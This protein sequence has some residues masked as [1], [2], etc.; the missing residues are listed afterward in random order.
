MNHHFRCTA[1]GKCCVGWVPLGVEEIAAQAARFPIAMV[2]TPIAAPPT[3]AAARAGRLAIRALPTAYVPPSFPCPQLAA[4]GL[5]AI[6]ATKPQRCRTMPFWPHRPEADQAAMLAPRDGWACDVSA[7][8]PVVYQ[9]GR[10]LDRA[11]FDRERAMMAAQAPV[12][13][14]YV[15]AVMKAAPGLSDIL[16]KVAATPG[17][18]VVLSITTLLPHLSGF[19]AGAFARAQ[20]PVLADFAARTQGQAEW[21]AYHQRYGEWG[22]EMEQLASR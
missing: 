19:D 7:A 11:D 14:A 22:R 20:A 2:W 12:L 3:P 4:D 9:D 16:A 17:G 6:H 13:A 18:N 1:C 10:I 5:C 8:A 15:D 21:A